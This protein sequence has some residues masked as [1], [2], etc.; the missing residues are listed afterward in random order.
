MRGVTAAPIPTQFRRRSAA[1]LA[2]V[3]VGAAALLI[4]LQSGAAAAPA[5]PALVGDAATPV[6]TIAGKLSLT[7]D[8]AGGLTTAGATLKV[9][10]RGFDTATGIYLAICHAD[11]KAPASLKDCVG[12]A[13]PG[14]NTTKSWAHVSNKAPADGATVLPWGA[15]GSFSVGLALPASDSASDALDCAK[16]PCAVYTASD[17]GRGTAENLSVPLVYA[18]PATSGS[19]SA[20]STPPS[21]TSP[22]QPSSTPPSS[23]PPVSSPPSSSPASSPQSSTSAAVPTTVEAKSVRSASIAAGGLQ[24]VLFAGFTKDEPVTVMLY[25]APQALP[26]TRAD[27]DGVV[28]LDFTVPANLEPGTHLVRVVGQLSKV[29]GVASFVVT[30]PVVA[31]SAVAVPSTRATTSVASSSAPVSSAVPVPATLSPAS[32]TPASSTVVSSAIAPVAPPAS[33]SRAVWPWY[34]LGALLAILAGVV[35]YLLNRRFRLAVERRDNDAL[36]ADA[37]AAEHERHL[38]AIARANADAP[39]AYLGDAEPGGTPTPPTG[40]YSGYHPGEHGLLSGRDHP[41]SPGLLSGTGYRALPP[42]EPPTTALPAAGSARPD[43]ST[44]FLPGE[45]TTYLPGEA[46]TSLPGE[47]NPRSAGAGGRPN[48]SPTGGAQPDPD[49][50]TAGGPPTGS[51]RPDFDDEPFGPSTRSGEESPESTGDEPED[52]ASGGR[53]SRPN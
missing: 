10:G 12:G 32:S 50:A 24:E 14:G 39:T 11:G 46:T 6:T 44:T 48:P 31:S 16:V 9:A 33:A 13:I 22:V 26:A 18:A 53:H 47:N 4:A 17:Q 20:V 5:A 40:G 28:K 36:L 8:P 41:D 25:S 1:A 2:A 42:V 29:T 15:G 23:S 51:W 45:P 35:A 34:A 3:A 7:V 27:G 43:D 49:D 38:D 19:S 52:P 30:A 37:A 21:S